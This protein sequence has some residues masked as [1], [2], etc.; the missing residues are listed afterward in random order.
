MSNKTQVL[1]EGQYELADDVV[2]PSADRRY[3]RQ[4]EAMP[5]WLTGMKFD[6]QVNTF[7]HNEV[8]VKYNTVRAVGFYGQ[9]SS[10]NDGFAALVAKLTPVNR[11]VESLAHAADKNYVGA[12][13]LFKTLVA[14]Y[15]W[16]LD[17]LEDLV[18]TTTERVREE[19]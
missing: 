7:D 1:P 19:D 4:V 2:N 16:D 8:H 11:S 6:V 3:K 5:V 12:E 15:D 10:H 17:Q 18:N 9:V 13:D 14:S